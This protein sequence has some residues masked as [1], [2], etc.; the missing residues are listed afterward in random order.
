MICLDQVD[1]T[2]DVARARLE[3]SDRPVL[4]VAD[5]Q[6]GGRGRQGR[7]WVEPD[8][9]MF[10][11][12]AFAPD[13]EPDTWPLLPLCVG[14]AVRR[15]VVAFTREALELKWPNDLRLPHGKAGGVL[16]ESSDGVV[17]AG[18]GLNLFW[19]E[20]PDFA[21]ALFDMDPGPQMAQDLAAAW[22]VEMLALVK[23][24]ADSWPE[25]EYRDA[26]VTLGAHVEWDGGSGTA[27]DLGSTGALIVET[28]DGRTEI[29][30]GDVHLRSHR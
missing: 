11:S 19:E 5:R 16:V 24:G 27:V 18:C 26:C 23:A 17:T 12:L 2:Q 6:V 4:V 14:V 20:R 21:S 3:S 22:V 28:T 8:R 25:A 10:S 7:V 15:A 13:W 30:S 1:S 29:A 9:G